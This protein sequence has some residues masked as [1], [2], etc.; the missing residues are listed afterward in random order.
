MKKDGAVFTD[1]R[2]ILGWENGLPFININGEEYLLT[3]HP[4][5]PC[6][7]ITDNDGGMTA[8]H[9]AFDPSCVLESF[10]DGD[11]VTSITGREYD[12]SDFCEMVEYASGLRDIQIDDAEK[13]FRGRSKKKNPGQNKKEEKAEAEA[14]A[15]SESTLPVDGEILSNDPAYALIAEYPDSDVDF[16]L[17]KIRHAEPGYYA[18]REALV[19][20]C[21][22]LFTDDGE[23]I[24]RYDVGKAEAKRIGADE[25]FSA[26]SK[27]GA[28]NFRKAFLAPPYPNGYTGD[29]FDRLSQALFPKGTGGLEVYEWSTSWSEYFDEGRE[30][31]GALC[32]T[33]Y[34]GT[35]DRF[36]VIMASATD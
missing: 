12:A 24:W 9:N 35:C 5:E 20:A 10:A 4:Y 27:D 25:L 32:L 18:H 11:T 22:E 33:V 26:A 14:P 34:D 28:L 21:V 15:G 31:W 30:W 19:R 1:G 8:V 17:V 7:Y 13:V 6:L 2:Y 23:E 29:D 3:C 16:C 36:V